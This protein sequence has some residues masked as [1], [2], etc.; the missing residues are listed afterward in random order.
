[1]YISNI[2]R[3]DLVTAVNKLCRYASDPSHAHYR[4]LF[5]VIT[6][7]YQT[8]D[9]YLRYTQSEDTEGADPF[10]LYAASDSSYADCIDTGRSTIGRA[11]WMGSKTRGLI[12][13]KS[14]VPSN[15]AMSTTQAELQ[16]A[17][18]AS[19]DIIYRRALLYELGY[20]QDGS[21]RLYV[22]NNSCI[23][24]LDAVSSITKSRHYI[25]MLRQVQETRHLGIIHPYRIDSTDNPADVFTK[26]LPTL[27]YWRLTTQIMGDD[28][29]THSHAQFR[30]RARLQEVSGG[31]VKGLNS[32]VTEINNKVAS[33]ADKDERKREEM[34][35]KRLAMMANLAVTNLLG[36]LIDAGIL[37]AALKGD[38]QIPNEIGQE[39]PGHCDEQKQNTS[40][41]NINTQTE[42]KDGVNVRAVG[43]LDHSM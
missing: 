10:R 20:E 43:G 15:V 3:P 42:V 1:M 6:F 40:H 4:A 26:A 14:T 21:T 41:L 30:K 28:L 23:A 18:E 39:L 24:Q 2:S 38:V 7:A 13:W 34:T 35:G 16:A 25:V 37:D 32:Q 11:L 9:R 33:K 17:S 5:K 27:P 19:K 36:K 31:S 8:R 12:D 22:D 29:A